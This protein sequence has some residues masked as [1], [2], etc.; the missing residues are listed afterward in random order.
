MPVNV[1]EGHDLHLKVMSCH[2]H[3]CLTEVCKFINGT[4]AEKLLAHLVDDNGI[5]GIF[6][7]K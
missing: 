5:L 6:S 1:V 2:L 3:E 4:W 7:V